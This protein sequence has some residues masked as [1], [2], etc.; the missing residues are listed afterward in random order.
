MK[1]AKPG[2]LWGLNISF[3]LYLVSLW[4]A[5]YNMRTLGDFPLNAVVGVAFTALVLLGFLSSVMAGTK[6][7]W[8]LPFG[9]ALILGV[10]LWLF[11]PFGVFFSP[12]GSLILPIVIGAFFIAPWF[13]WLSSCYNQYLMIKVIY[14]GNYVLVVDY[15]DIDGPLPIPVFIIVN[16][17]GDILS[18]DAS[19]GEEFMYESSGWSVMLFDTS[20]L[21]VEHALSRDWYVMVR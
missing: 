11:P 10:G 16:V 13:G 8:A 5:F 7:Y 21:A 2:T 20:N 18:S 15:Q 4:W 17:D 19:G 9:C 14:K 12:T 6:W 3:G 1:I